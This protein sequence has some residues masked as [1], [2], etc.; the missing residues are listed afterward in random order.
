MTR[1]LCVGECMLEL[2][3]TDDRAMKLGFAGD[4]FNAAVYLRRVSDEL[5]ADVEVAYLS[6][7][8]DDYYSEAMRAEWA[9]FGIRDEAIV[10]PGRAP[11]LYTVRTDAA[12]ERTFAYWRSDSAARHL[13]AGREWA[14]RLDGDVL[15]L[16]GITLQLMTHESR[17][18][19]VRELDCARER[20]RKIV[21]DTNYRPAGWESAAEAAHAMCEVIRRSDIVL[22]TLDDEVALHGPQGPQQA[23]R[24]VAEL[25]PREV[26]I[27]VGAQGAWLHDHH[28]TTHIPARPVPSVVDTTAAGDSFAGAYL[29]ARL[30]GHR[31]VRAAALANQVGAEVIGQPGA[32][33]PPEVK[34]SHIVQP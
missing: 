8:G 23:C 32:I 29:A 33:T 18:L 7:I 14:G 2:R 19:L 1:V 22:A 6:G 17:V 25:G 5:G 16:S 3:H 20:G 21:F 13:F 26:V 30:A 27:K 4:T 15:Y 24:R 34:L 12:G 11:G 28:S 10:V 9:G 31:P